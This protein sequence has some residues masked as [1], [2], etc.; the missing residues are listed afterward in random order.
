M[1]NK[2]N[3]VSLSLPVRCMIQR[4]IGEVIGRV[5]DSREGATRQTGGGGK[6]RPVC[7]YHNTPLKPDATFSKSGVI[8]LTEYIVSPKDQLPS[9]ARKADCPTTRGNGLNRGFLKMSV[10]A[11]L[12]YPGSKSKT[13]QDKQGL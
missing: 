5:H 1:P 4:T 2:F 7:V 12:G 13:T 9:D 10:V 6:P 8:N 3:I 11:S